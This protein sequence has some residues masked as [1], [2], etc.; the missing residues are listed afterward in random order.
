MSIAFILSGCGGGGGDS[1]PPVPV[2]PG[3]PSGVTAVAGPAQARIS[4][5]NVTGATSYN[6]YRSA[7]AGVTKA[8]GTKISN[9]NSPFVVTQLTN[10]RRTISW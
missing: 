4:W 5:D 9:V 8:T 10:G 7:T 6:L 1:S 3:A 2:V